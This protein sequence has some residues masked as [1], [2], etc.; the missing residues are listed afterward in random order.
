MRTVFR[1]FEGNVPAS[2]LAVLLP[3]ALQQPEEF[4]H[5]GFDTDLRSRDL[6]ADLLLVDFELQWIGQA[7]DGHAVKLLYE[8]MRDACADKAYEKIWLVGISIGGAIASA[9]ALAYPQ[10]V[11]GLCLLS[12]YPGTRSLTSQI[13]RAGGVRNWNPATAS[14]EEGDASLWHFARQYCKG[15]LPV[16]LGYGRQDR[17][18][19]GL[20]MLEN[21]FGRDCIDVIDGAHDW[22]TWIELWNK[23]LPRLE[24]HVNAK[25][26]HP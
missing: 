16:Y 24:K 10:T 5:A 11:T 8:A 23:F 15:T 12:P 6:A 25:A 1:P 14:Q 20:A 9:Y 17:F 7:A 13:L 26:M 19:D 18:A 2:A 3:G 4:L 22:P 21:V